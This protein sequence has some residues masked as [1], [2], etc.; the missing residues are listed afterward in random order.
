MEKF[1]KHIKPDQCCN[2]LL[3]GLLQII[4]KLKDLYTV[5]VLFFNFLFLKKPNMASSQITEILQSVISGLRPPNTEYGLHSVLFYCC[6]ECF[7]P[8]TCSKYSGRTHL[9][10]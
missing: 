6:T 1:P 7:L 5:S 3:G 4:G 9:G 2:T 10:F 8:Q